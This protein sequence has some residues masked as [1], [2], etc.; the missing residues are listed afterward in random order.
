MT[1]TAIRHRIDTRASPA[2]ASHKPEGIS[3][4]VRACL[5]AG[6]TF[7][8]MLFGNDG[9]DTEE[10]ATENAIRKF[11]GEIDP[12]Y[13]YAMVKVWCQSR[14]CGLLRRFPGVSLQIKNRA[15]LGLLSYDQWTTRLDMRHAFVAAP[16]QQKVMEG[17]RA[18]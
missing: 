5:D 12:K 7:V 1:P 9:V 4:R 11:L 6:G 3:P 14:I 16:D 18:A 10:D 8:T 2:G 13:K 17:L 15:D